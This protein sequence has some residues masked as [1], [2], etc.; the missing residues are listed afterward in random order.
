MKIC[1]IGSGYV[2]LV[3]GVCLAEFGMEIVCVDKDKVKIEMMRKGQ[4]PFYE[5]GLDDLIEKN[6]KG[7]RLSF[8]TDTKKGVVAS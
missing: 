3:T 1:M 6:M 7:G 5:P 8:S 2:G 4:S